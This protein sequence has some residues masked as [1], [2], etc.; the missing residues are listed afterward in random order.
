MRDAKEKK[1]V[2]FFLAMRLDFFP[3]KFIKCVKSPRHRALF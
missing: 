2:R 1:R 3:E